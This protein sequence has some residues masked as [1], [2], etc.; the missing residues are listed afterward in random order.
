MLESIIVRDRAEKTLLGH[1]GQWR[2]WRNFAAEEKF[3]HLP[4]SPL[5]VAIFLV[6]RYQGALSKK[7][8]QQPV[9]KSAEAIAYVHTH[10]Q[11][12]DPVQSA[13]PQAVVAYAYRI[14][15]R[16]AKKSQRLTAEILSKLADRFAKE[17]DAGWLM[18]YVALLL[19]FTGFLRHDDLKH[20]DL[21]L[22]EFEKDHM[23]LF[24]DKSKTDQFRV[25]HWVVIAAIG[26]DLCPVGNLRK[27]MLLAGVSS[28]PL[29]RR[30]S[31]SPSGCTVSAYALSYTTFLENMRAALSLAGMSK[32]EAKDFGTRCMRTGGASAAAECGVPDRLRLK[33]GRWVSE[34]VGN[35]YVQ[36]SLA[37][38]LMVTRNLGLRV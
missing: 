8:T 15:A 21:Q 18:V 6:H 26:G 33:H 4:A 17:T 30:V 5:H 38:L 3:P 24:V 37:Q 34:S 32:E 35:G 28:G 20:I 1:A 29:L 12:S 19:G 7:Q 9:V 36:D 13:L 31:R 22:V 11:F 25:G 14:L 2:M 23:R 10:C 27:W 16:P